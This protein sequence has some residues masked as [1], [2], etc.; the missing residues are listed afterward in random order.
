MFVRRKAENHFKP[1]YRDHY[2]K[3]FNWL[4][5]L[6]EHEGKQILHQR[7]N[8][9]EVRVGPYPVDGF[10]AKNRIVYQFQGK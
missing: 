3:A 8:G 1:E 5:Y 7:N 4:N 6:I 10:D 2:M 9:R